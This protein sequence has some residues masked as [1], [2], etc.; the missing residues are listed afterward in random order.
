VNIRR[1]TPDDAESL[2]N[3]AFNAKAHW[4]YPAAWMEQWRA[5]L[6]F[7]PDYFAAFESWVAENEKS[8][9]AFYTLQE[10]DGEGWIENLWVS[11]MFIGKG[12]GKILFEHALERCKA[13]EFRKLLL[14]SDPHAIGFYERMGMRQ[15]GGRRA[16]M[17]G[18]P[19]E[20][21]LMEMEV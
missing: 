9:I 16:D 18:Q 1:A 13:L 17:G 15:L 12:V 14:E 21:P 11:P 7:S 10:R 2:S 4:G 3:I 8:P 19:R 20:I 6:I 5:E